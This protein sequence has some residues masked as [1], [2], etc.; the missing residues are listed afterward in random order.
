MMH[1]MTN[2]VAFSGL[3]QGLVQLQR[4]YLAYLTIVGVSHAVLFLIKRVARTTKDQGEQSDGG[5]A[6]L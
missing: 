3:S 4:Y 1:L 5:K 6:L 2:L